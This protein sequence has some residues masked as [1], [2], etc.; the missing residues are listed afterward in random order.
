MT[1]ASDWRVKIAHRSQKVHPTGMYRFVRPLLF[2]LD[3]ERAHHLSMWA[4]RLVQAISPALIEPLFEYEDDALAQSIWGLDFPNPVGLA[5]GFDK[6]ARLVPFWERVGFGFVEVGSV[7]ARPSAGNPRPRAFRLPDDEALINRMGLNNQGAESIA[8][9]LRRFEQRR[10]RPL[11]INIVK[12]HDPSIMGAEAL[13]DFRTSFR[14]LAPSAD[15]MALNISCPNTQEG[16]TFEAPD[17]LDDLLDAIFSER[18]NLDV[19]VPILLK[20]APPLS[21]Q[22]IF[23]SQVEEIVTVAETHGVHGFIAA[24]TASDRN[25]LSTDPAMLDAIGSGGLSGPPLAKRSTRLVRYLH[26]KTDGAVPIIGVGGVNSAESAYAKIR[27][28]ASLVQLY[29]GL[30]YEGPGLIKRIK[31][32]LVKRLERDGFATIQEAVGTAA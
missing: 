24:N 13:D 21:A 15:Y 18:A 11:G 14:A 29:T 30:I 12:T 19:D 26:Q 9:R 31:E 5:A 25:G 27:A 32:G 17:A 20:L 4:A 23:D 8:R 3:A 7:S 28:G 16:K 10:S 22:V 6:N 2:R 1:T